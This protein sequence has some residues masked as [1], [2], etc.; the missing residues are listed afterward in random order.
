M[1]TQKIHLLDPLQAQQI[2]AG[3][4]IERPANIVKEL[5]E[6]SIDAGA[7]TITV[8][9]E[10]A[11]KQLIS[12]A[13]NGCGM[14]A[15][16]AERCFARHATSKLTNVD[17]LTSLETFGFRGEALASIAAVGSVSL[18]TKE[19]DEPLLGTQISYHHGLYQ[20]SR[21]TA[22]PAGTSI[23]IKDLFGT[24]PVRKTF[25]KQD[26]TEWNQ[27]QAV[28][29]GI[30]L[31]HLNVSFML[32]KD[33][34]RAIEAPA[35]TTLKDRITQLWNHTLSAQLTQLTFND[36]EI[37]VEGLISLPPYARYGKDLIM[38]WVNNR[39]VKN[40][41]ITRAIT[42]GYL[43]SLP[44]GKYP[45]AFLAITID[46]ATV[47]VN[48]HPRKEE[49]RFTKPGVVTTCIQKGITSALEAAVSRLDAKWIA[50]SPMTPRN[51]EDA[52]RLR[53]HH[54]PEY[55]EENPERKATND[56]P[57][58]RATVMVSHYHS[59]PFQ[60]SFTGGLQ[61]PV[62]ASEAWQSIN[63]QIS[64]QIPERPEWIASS[65]MAPRNDGL[66]DDRPTADDEQPAS[67]IVTT[68]HQG[69][70]ASH[71]VLLEA[72]G[73]RLVGQIFN[74]YILVELDEEFIIID[75]HAA[76]ERVLYHQF[77]T[78]FTNKEGTQLLFP[79]T[80]LLENERAVAALIA[81]SDF[82]A[83][84]GIAFAQTGPL[85]LTITSAPPQLQKES[86]SS[87]VLDAADFIATHDRLDPELF[88]QKLNEHVH[89]H[90]ACKLAV[91][92]GDALSIPIMEDLVRQLL[93]T[94]NR[95]M[96]IHGRPTMWPIS[97][98]ELEK[99]FK[100]RG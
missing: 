91:K 36:R 40:S 77:T 52:V 65:P 31:T 85:H 46:P 88:R 76:H 27:I 10:K 50:A 24:L 11:G 43:Q 94:P 44:P 81:E 98:F 49:V 66:R 70:K 83:S 68:N 23:V 5:I 39:L 26:E 32:Y 87:V 33:G 29:H 61:P 79:E 59:L 69:S 97:L 38:F 71:A 96:C 9:I 82:F 34:E 6:N 42:K 14:S 90:L 7:T 84:Q 62:I 17:Q 30:A 35:V 92:A 25:L 60:T 55:G 16:D 13:D 64:L 4:V 86:L 47:D 8:R 15:L 48:I 19:Q 12:V 56:V 67:A 80:I 75:Q 41:D 45:A 22:C 54:S 72:S 1:K 57:S 37:A 89:S 18:T 21:E 20:G 3:E 93:A 100:R 95:F 63:Q 58:A 2:A 73:A 51:D 78:K 28:V 53:A 99:R 74:T